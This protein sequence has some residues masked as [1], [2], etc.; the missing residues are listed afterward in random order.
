MKPQ[1]TVDLFVEKGLPHATVA[2]DFYEGYRIPAG[3]IVIANAWCVDTFIP[4]PFCLPDTYRRILHD[5]EIYPEPY[6]FNPERFL[7]NAS[8]KMSD[9]HPA[10]TGCF[11]YG[12]RYVILSRYN[13]LG[14]IKPESVQAK[15]WPMLR[16]GWRWHH[17]YRH[18]T[19]PT[20]ATNMVRYLNCLEL[21]FLH[22]A[23]L[24]NCIFFFCN[25]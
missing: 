19:L 23:R 25:D 3:S 12:R 20:L 21:S 1:N 8:G 7:P 16:Y 2:E 22:R 24:G 6:K 5:A 14:L 17:F 4:C 9:K 15:I 11:G 18:L 10:M 13:L